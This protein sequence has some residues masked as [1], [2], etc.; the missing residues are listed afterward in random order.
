MVLLMGCAP[1]ND[2]PD[3][4]PAPSASE[5]EAVRF[6]EQS[7]WGPTE[8]GVSD[9]RRKGLARYLE[10]QFAMP[11]TLM[12]AFRETP[13]D[14]GNSPNPQ[15]FC[16]QPANGG[17]NCGRD[18]FTLSQLQRHF[19]QAG[20][21]GKDQLRQRVAFALA[22]IFVVSGAGGNQI[23]LPYAM[24]NYQRT[25]HDYAFGNFSDL[26]TQVTLSPAMGHY[27]NMANNDKADP[28]AKRAPN[29][30][31]AREL[32]QLFTIGTVEL[33]ADGSARK[34]VAGR[35]LPAYDQTIVENFA[36][37]FSGWTFPQA[38]DPVAVGQETWG[39]H[40]SPYFQGS[41]TPVPDEHDMD[42]KTLLRGTVLPAG[43]T[44]EK[45][46][47]DAIANIFRHPNVGPF[48]GRRLI[49]HLVT[50]NPSPAYVKRVAATFDNNGQGARGD[51]KAVIRAILLDPE[52]RGERKE[53]PGYG[54]VR[55]PA[56]FA[57]GLMRLLAATTDGVYPA[58]QCAAMG[59]DVYSPPSVFG[60]YPADY[61]LSDS[62]LTS[63]VSAI[64][65]DPAALARINFANAL[66]FSSNGVAPDASV[67]GATG[68]RVNLDP[69][70]AVAAD[71]EKLLDMLD[72]LMLHGT[73][74]A[75]TR[76]TIRDAL[77]AVPADNP[78]DRARTAVY[79]M[80]ASPLYQVQR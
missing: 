24:V 31:F 45:D 8:G 58:V 47:K 54:R 7:S 50:S 41:M 78:W 74:D 73:L 1:Q 23:R 36:R 26:L 48:I 52:A 61:P 2:S 79:L 42:K 80:A 9:V 68:T 27:L 62:A 67:P 71:E 14:G 28:G 32:L 35:P 37:A 75:A 21:E 64:F 57:I 15:A 55:E 65:T 25:L 5:A 51:L 30:N 76:T 49:Q 39:A 17:R 22:Q 77:V 43:Q 53:D 11:A 34:D 3:V 44:H 66:L 56:Q 59:Q 33:N 40:R 6:L 72:R 63:P 10:E 19:I 12:P 70:A 20:V 18:Y 4:V 69:L 60:F 29:E 38:S 16:N 13:T 46:L